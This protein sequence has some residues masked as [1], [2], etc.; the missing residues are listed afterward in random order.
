[1]Q[2][3]VPKYFQNRDITLRTFFRKLRLV[4]PCLYSW[5]KNLEVQRY[6][7]FL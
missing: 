5:Y 3:Y 2:K 1:M 4:Y 7:T 6:N